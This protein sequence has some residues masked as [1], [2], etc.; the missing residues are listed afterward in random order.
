VSDA[1]DVLLRRVAQATEGARDADPDAVYRELPRAYRTSAD[2]TGA[3]LLGLLEE[4]LVDYGVDVAR[5]RS[6]DLGGVIADELTR[7]RAHRV[8]LPDGAPD[9]WRTALEGRSIVPS[10]ADPFELDTA[11]ATLS[12][13]AVVVAETG[14]IVLDGA[15][16]Q[17]RRAATLVPD[18]HLC[19]VGASQVV[20]LVPEAIARLEDAAHAGAAFTWISGPSAT[21]D[22]ELVRVAGVHGPRRVIVLLVEDA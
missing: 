6:R 10:D 4:R 1:R 12:G 11:D 2:G 15:P 7:L 19:V 8:V 9:A 20:R 22:I 3:E 5:T 18:V 13:C 17:G 21:S 14:T 16:D